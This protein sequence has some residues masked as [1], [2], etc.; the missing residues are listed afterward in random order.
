MVQNVSTMIGNGITRVK[1]SLLAFQ[2][3]DDT[4][5]IASA[6]VTSL[7]SLKIVLRAFAAISGLKVNYGKS[8]FV[9]MNVSS[10]HLPWV[11]AVLGCTRK[12][13]PVQYLGMP[14]TVGRPAR[15]LFLPMIEKVEGKLGGWKGKML[16]RGGRLQL[17]QSV[18]STIPSYHMMCFRLPQ[19]AITRIDKVRR[20]LLWGKNDESQRG[21]SLT[22]WPMACNPR[23]FGGL[24]IANLNLVNITY[25]LRWWWKAYREE[26]SLWTRIIHNLRRKRPLI[27]GPQFWTKAGSFFWSQL[28]RIKH[29]FD[30]SS[31]WEVGVGTTIS[32]WYDAWHGLP[33][34]TGQEVQVVQPR[35]SLQEA[36]TIQE[37]INP[38]H[39]SDTTLTFNE[40]PDK[41][42]W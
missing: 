3:A 33:L 16:S 39:Q 42:C 9:P 5:V 11:Q 23:R 6:D 22:N 17:V 32:Y 26:A 36:W 37:L 1:E 35:I 28:Q 7:I 19:W 29:I 25:L 18:L 31:M 15:E 27:Q 34:A 21:I 8:I 30:W 4:A 2:Y 41:L 38:D 14:M 40:A 12:S 20:Q 13:F 10:E 24:G